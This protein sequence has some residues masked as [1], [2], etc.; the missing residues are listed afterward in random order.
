MGDSS[1]RERAPASELTEALNG[2]RATC[3]LATAVELGLIDAL[4]DAPRDEEELARAL[5][6]HRPS[7]QRLLRALQ[8]LGIV[9]PANGAVGLTGA[10]RMLLDDSLA[11]CDRAVLA[12]GEYLPAW[13][14]LRHSVLTGEPAFDGVFGMNVWQHREVNPRLG[15]A[16]QRVMA[17]DYAQTQHAVVKACDLDDCRLVVDVGGGRG[18]LLVQLLAKYPHMQ[19][20]L[21][22]QPSVVNEAMSLAFDAGVRD[23]MR[24]VGGSFFEAVPEG[25]DA[26]LLQHILHDWDDEPCLQILRACREAMRPAS[27]LLIIENVLPDKRDADIRLAMLDLHMMAVL[28]GRER[29]QL[30]YEALL[31]SAGF[32]PVK[33]SKTHTH[34]EI[35]VATPSRPSG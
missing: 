15:E 8:A 14:N 20:I 13:A 3:V 25:G 23:R 6:A 10:G 31:T 17:A 30:D 11:L 24:A 28:G 9:H 27:R 33:C 26:Y 34:C 21:F 32:E 12:A 2:Y 7:L 19:G 1:G 35:M 22:D 16:F 29:T 18:H 4:R 5:G